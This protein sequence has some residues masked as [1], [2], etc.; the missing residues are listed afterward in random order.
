M[1]STGTQREANTHG[2]E[3]LSVTEKYTGLAIIRLPLDASATAAVGTR[4]V[5]TS[6]V[7]VRRTMKKLPTK[8]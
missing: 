5:Q 8:I 4:A 2:C 3:A 7:V 6:A 1:R